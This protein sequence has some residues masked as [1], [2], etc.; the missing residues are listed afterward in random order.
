MTT[1]MKTFLPLVVSVSLLVGGQ[2]ALKAGM[3]QIGAID[4]GNLRMVVGLVGRVFT[5]PTVLTGVALYVASSFF[6]LIALSQVELSYA[7]PFVG[8][9]YVLVAL[10]SWLVLGEA[11]TLLRWAGIALIVAGV[12][13]VS[14]S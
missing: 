13:L 1:R 3:N 5:T 2:L 11:L 9:G 7:Y 14:R 6:W 4:I 12:V 8:L 10:F